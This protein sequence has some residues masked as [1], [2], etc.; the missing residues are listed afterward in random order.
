MDLRR[1]LQHLETKEPH[2]WARPHASPLGN[3]IY[4]IRFKSAQGQFRLFGH[5]DQASQ[6][7]VIT[8]F[9]TEKDGKYDPPNY[10]DIANTRMGQCSQHPERHTCR[11]L[12]PNA[13]WR[14]ASMDSHGL[15][16]P[17]VVK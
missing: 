17:R 7:F 15:F 6:A 13:E 11:S 4:V 1:S 10:A 16:T 9:G 12:D 2:Y 3:H 14:W 5:H 8:V